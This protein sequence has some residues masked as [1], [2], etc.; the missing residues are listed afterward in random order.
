MEGGMQKFSTSSIIGGECSTLW[1][2]KKTNNYG[3]VCSTTSFDSEWYEYFSLRCKNRCVHAPFLSYATTKPSTTPF[4]GVILAVVWLNISLCQVG[5]IYLHL[6]GTILPLTS[7][8]LSLTEIAI[9]LLNISKY[10]PVDTEGY[11]RFPEE[12]SHWLRNS[13]LWPQSLSNNMH[14]IKTFMMFCYDIKSINK[15]LPLLTQHINFQT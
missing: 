6:G 9:F 7:V 1:T 13:S 10:S 12:S 5:K 8:I 11:R 14:F 15:K 2:G 3:Y 4:F